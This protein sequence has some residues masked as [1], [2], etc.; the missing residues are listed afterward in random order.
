MDLGLKGRRALVMGASK[1]LGR[2][3]ADSLAEE[4][5]SVVVSGRTQAS[6]DQVAADLKA[7]G[8]AAAHGVP[9][10]VASAADLD[11]LAEEAA[12]LMGGVDILVLNHGGPPPG[13]ATE[14]SEAQ[15]AEWFPRMVLHPIRIAMRLLPA[16]RAQRWGRIVLVGS[17]GMVEPIPT[18]AISNTLRGAMVGWCKSLAG[19]VAGDGVTVNILAPGAILTDRSR[20]TAAGAAAKRGVP[21]ETVIDERAA[22]IPARRYGVPAEFGPMGAF[23]ASERG[24]YVTGT[25]VRVDGGAVRG[26]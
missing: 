11:R 2:A 3:I 15:L 8:A 4:G 14:V 22:T 21:V 23:L 10:D 20:E 18:L 12:R 24:A 5:A 26:F 7:R 1:G 19:E 6:L 25:I 17:S 13:T 9:A 16:M